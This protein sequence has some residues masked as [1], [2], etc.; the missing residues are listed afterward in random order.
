MFQVGVIFCDPEKRKGLLPRPVY[1]AQQLID[2]EN[3]IREER[4]LWDG[5]MR[6]DELQRELKW[7]Q[8]VKWER[9]MNKWEGDVYL[10]DKSNK[11]WESSLAVREADILRKE[12][13]MQ[14]N[15]QL[16]QRES[17]REM[18]VCLCNV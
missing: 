11:V 13:E 18:Q 16:S 7:E 14:N 5:R 12:L 8:L 3:K 17:C 9:N 1:S 10:R 2:W 15:V 6:E 4:G